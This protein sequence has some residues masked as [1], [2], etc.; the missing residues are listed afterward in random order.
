MKYHL[1]I[2]PGAA[3]DLLE[4]ANW[5]EDQKERLG[6]R[7]LAAVDEKLAMVTENPLHYQVRYKT[8]RF[9]LVKRFPY[10]I[11]YTVEEDTIYVLAVLS[12]HRNPREWKG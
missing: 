9:A 6:K 2:K 7:F 1:I 3:L 10:A 12:T 11:H 5:F 4:S 8:T